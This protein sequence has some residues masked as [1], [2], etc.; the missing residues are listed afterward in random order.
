MVGRT[1]SQV[2]LSAQNCALLTPL[3]TID[4]SLFSLVIDSP[5]TYEGVV[6][7]NTDCD[8]NKDNKWLVMHIDIYT[9][10][11]IYTFATFLKALFPHLLF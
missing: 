3:P 1:G 7:N 5:I 6:K 11:Y 9:H 10:V 8:D 4:R 2:S